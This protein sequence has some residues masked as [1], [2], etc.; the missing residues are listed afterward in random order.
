MVGDFAEGPVGATLKL[1][2]GV[3]LGTSV[4]DESIFPN[5]KP[6]RGGQ[7]RPLAGEHH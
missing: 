5:S 3:I 6:G 1:P 4:C 7:W 2:D